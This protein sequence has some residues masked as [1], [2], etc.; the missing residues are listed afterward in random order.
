MTPSHRAFEFRRSLA[1][2]NRVTETGGDRPTFDELDA[3]ETEE[4]K[5]RALGV[6]RQRGDAAFLWELLEHLPQSARFAGEDGAT[7][8]V[9]TTVND[10]LAVV[11]EVFGRQ[12]GNVGDLEPL[13]RARFVDYL[14]T[15]SERG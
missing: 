2:L 9:V 8:G 5:D 14:L 10:V 7:T 4:L 1:R 6:A 11:E 15:H 13:L 3:L 12:M